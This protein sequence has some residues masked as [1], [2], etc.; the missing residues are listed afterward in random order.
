MSITII[1]Q[2]PELILSKQPVAFTVQS[3][4]TGTP[5]RIKANISG[6]SASDS[7]AV[8]GSLQA[9]FELSDYLQGLVTSRYKTDNVPVVYTNNPAVVQVEFRELVGSPPAVGDELVSDPFY[10]LDGYVP[11]P[12]RKALYAEYSS[13]Y[14]YIL[15]KN[16]FL[17][18]FPA[19]EKKEVA[20]NQ[21]E[22][23]NYLQIWSAEP[24]TLSSRIILYFT[25][26]GTA[27]KNNVF[28]TLPNVAFGSMV[29][30]PCGYDQ[31]NIQGLMDTTYNMKTL[32]YYI[33]QVTGMFN[34]GMQQQSFRL[35]TTYQ[36]NIRELYIRN[37]FGLLEI[38]RCTGKGDQNNKLTIEIA[39]TDGRILPDKISWKN[40]RDYTVKAN[41]GHLSKAQMQWLSDMDFIEAYELQG[42]VLHPIVFHDIDLPVIHDDTYQYSAELEYEY[43]FNEIVE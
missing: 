29:Y 13:L 31:L 32:D 17:S 33:F 24:V 16:N 34:A 4:E 21:K 2:P 41:V 11:K 43:V 12:R 26:G 30:F 40:E 37:P 9:E 20:R 5:L 36:A 7:V 23:V 10:L 22:F 38:V 1:K 27:T 18:W 14:S 25:D 42:T 15:A 39:R 6:N 35:N 3:N 19:G 28:T 8:N